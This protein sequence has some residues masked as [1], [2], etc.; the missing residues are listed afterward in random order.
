[1]LLNIE[2]G[3]D[4][5]GGRGGGPLRDKIFSGETAGDNSLSGGRGEVSIYLLGAL[6]NLKNRTPPPLERQGRGPISKKGEINVFVHVFFL[7]VGPPG[8]PP[9]LDPPLFRD[10]SYCLS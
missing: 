5:A 10:P 6:E 8:T 4:P 9:P 3:A 1:M 2:T 7:G